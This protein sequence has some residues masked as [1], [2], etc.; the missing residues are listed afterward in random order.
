MANNLALDNVVI[1]AQLKITAIEESFGTNELRLLIEIVEPQTG[2][3]V[4]AD[5]LIL[6]AGQ[7]ENLGE[8]LIKYLKYF[9]IFFQ[10]INLFFGFVE[11]Y[12]LLFF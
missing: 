1:G 8:N 7:Y 9:S 4:P 3:F 6:E 5:I 11:F 12:I 10:K 2:E